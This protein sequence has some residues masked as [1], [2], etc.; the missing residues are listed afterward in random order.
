VRPEQRR[1]KDWSRVVFIEVA[2]PG[3]FFERAETR[4]LREIADALN[5]LGVCAQAYVFTKLS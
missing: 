2:P 3:Q 4:T 5:T 1:A